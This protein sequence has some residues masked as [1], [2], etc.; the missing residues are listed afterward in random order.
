[1]LIKIYFIYLTL[2]FL[3]LISIIYFKGVTLFSDTVKMTE[4]EMF[5]LVN[6]CAYFD[7]YHIYHSPH[8]LHKPHLQLKL[9]EQLINRFLIETFQNYDHYNPE[10]VQIEQELIPPQLHPFDDRV[11]YIL[12]FYYLYIKRY[13]TKF[14]IFYFRFVITLEHILRLI[15][16][17]MIMMMNEMR[18]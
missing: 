7:L 4:N 1:M 3:I 16:M 11:G 8:L 2:E 17:M 10:F 5:A 9:Q 15:V 14:Y 6:S 12:L 13:F 18:S